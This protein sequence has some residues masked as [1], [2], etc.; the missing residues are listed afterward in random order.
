MAYGCAACH[1]ADGDGKGPA[2]GL[3]K[4]APRN[5]L[6][7]GSYVQGTSLED[8][9]RSIEYGMKATGMPAYA[10][11]PREERLA[12]ATW[13]LDAAKEKR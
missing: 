3:S 4:I 5:L 2:A 12:M 11:L 6:D 8:I 7:L 9:S 13:I 10:E 1:G